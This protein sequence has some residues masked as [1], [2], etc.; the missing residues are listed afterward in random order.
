MYKII[1]EIPEEWASYF[2][3]QKLEIPGRRRAYVKFPPW[4][5][6][7]YFLELHIA[8]YKESRVESSFLATQRQADFYPEI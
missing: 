8:H 6:Y 2:S 7:G 1:V 4:W 3:G 5:G